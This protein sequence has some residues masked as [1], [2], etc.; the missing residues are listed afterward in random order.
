MCETKWPLILMALRPIFLL[1]TVTAK[2]PRINK[3]DKQKI[4]FLKENDLKIKTIVTKILTQQYE[5]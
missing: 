3:I 1:I 4:V 5:I 2:M